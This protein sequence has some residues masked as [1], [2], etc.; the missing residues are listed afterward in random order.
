[1]WK[2]C[3][4]KCNEDFHQYDKKIKINEQLSNPEMIGA[5]YTNVYRRIALIEQNAVLVYL[6]L[7]KKIEVKI[8]NVRWSV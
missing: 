3:E 6:F 2:S 4:W 7:L 5:S 8:K 1:M